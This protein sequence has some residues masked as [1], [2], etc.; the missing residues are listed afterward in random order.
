MFVLLVCY[1][2]FYNS[3]CFEYKLLFCAEF[4]DKVELYIQK[5][6]IDVLKDIWKSEICSWNGSHTFSVNI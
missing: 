2:M 4:E 5:N 3:L 1:L 6:I